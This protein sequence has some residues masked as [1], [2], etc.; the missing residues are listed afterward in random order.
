MNKEKIFLSYS[1]SDIKFAK[2]LVLDL[3]NSGSDVWIDED[4]SHG[5]SWN[6]EIEKVLNACNCLLVILSPTST[7]S[8][9]VNNEIL[10]ALQK[11]KRIIPLRIS[12]CDI[13]I[14]I[15]SLHYID[16]ISDYNVGLSFLLKA[17]RLKNKAKKNKINISIS[18][19]LREKYSKKNEEDENLWQIVEDD[20][21]I[22]SYKQY[23]KK[24]PEGRHRDEASYAIKILDNRKGKEK[25][26]PKSKPEKSSK[27]KLDKNK[28][29][30]DTHVK[31]NVPSKPKFISLRKENEIPKTNELVKRYSDSE[32]AEFRDLIDHL[33]K[34]LIRIENKTYGI[35]RVTGKLI[36]KD[37]LRAVPHATLSLE[38]IN[39]AK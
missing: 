1:R 35:C 26:I 31:K 36:E 22:K 32:L 17:L 12:E 11:K 25:L 21:T 27:L 4:L 29:N 34:A 19:K 3:R 23:L 24:Y 13:P 30:L 18:S 7:S 39:S 38:A 14:D 9:N 20:N 6:K 28:G 33:E 15:I 37:R 5:A 16:F 2:K 10:F 8:Y